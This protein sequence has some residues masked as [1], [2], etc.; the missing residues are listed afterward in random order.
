[1]D[2]RYVPLAIGLVL[3]TI[4]ASLAW[5]KVKLYRP[6]TVDVRGSAKRRINSNFAQWTANVRT[7][8]KDRVE[9]YRA[10][11]RDAAQVLKFV[12]AKGV[13]A[14]ETRTSSVQIV[15]VSH[16]ETTEIGPKTVEKRVFD[17]WQAE[18]RIEVSSADV[19]RVEQLSRE[20]TQLLEK[21]IVI[22]SDP[23]RYHYTKVG[24]LK[25]EMLAEASRDA[26]LRA[27]RMLGA[28]GAN[29]KVGRVV[30]LDTGVININAANSTETSWEGNYDTSSFEKDII[31]TVRVRFEVEN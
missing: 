25:I 23:P 31:T 7:Q 10:V 29:A 14:A 17:T 28:A 19:P 6:A 2:R 16:D 24:E 21:G 8:N 22:A 18:Q 15:E 12:Q 3:C 27:E 11:E 30:G 5:M 13:P 1:M 4:I 9:A 20:A 26:R